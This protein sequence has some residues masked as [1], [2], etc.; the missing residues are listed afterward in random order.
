MTTPHPLALTDQQLATVRRIG[1][2]IDQ[3]WRSRYLES[4]ADELLSCEVISDETVEVT[5]ARVAHRLMPATN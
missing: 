5:A 2:T 4:L 3:R 1:A